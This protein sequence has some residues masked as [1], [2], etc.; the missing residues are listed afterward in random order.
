MPAGAAWPKTRCGTDRA[1]PAPDG[2]RFGGRAD[3]QRLNAAAEVEERVHVQRLGAVGGVVGAGVQWVSAQVQLDG[4]EEA[5]GVGFAV[6]TGVAYAVVVKVY[7]MD[8]TLD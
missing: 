4:S 1:G 2:G 7:G 3:R 5:I 6:V 8:V